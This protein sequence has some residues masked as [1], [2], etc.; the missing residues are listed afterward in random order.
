MRFGSARIVEGEDSME[1]PT[2]KLFT[3]KKAV[4]MTISCVGGVS[5]WTYQS[6]RQKGHLDSV[7]VSGAAITMVIAFCVVALVGWW[8]NKEE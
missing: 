4:L 7:D 8:A 5:S 1:K 2:I 3:W 6:Y